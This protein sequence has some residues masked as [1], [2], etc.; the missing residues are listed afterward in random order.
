[1]EGYKGNMQCCLLKK[2]F[3][4]MGPCNNFFFFM[5]PFIEDHFEETVGGSLKLRTILGTFNIY[6]KQK[7]ILV[8]FL[9][10]FLLTCTI[11]KDYK[12][13]NNVGTCV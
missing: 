3:W 1:M 2:N 11:F 4:G 7:H 12:Y 10:F 13:F 5:K 6:K 9:I 8:L